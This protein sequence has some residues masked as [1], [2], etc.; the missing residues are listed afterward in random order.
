MG[1]T[2]AQLFAALAESVAFDAFFAVLK[3]VETIGAAKTGCGVLDPIRDGM[4]ACSGAF[5]AGGIGMLAEI[6][7]AHV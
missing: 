4:V 2:A 1:A 7:R 6:G 3:V 5:P